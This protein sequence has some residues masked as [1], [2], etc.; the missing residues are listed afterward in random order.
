MEID[1]DAMDCVRCWLELG[2][3]F[4]LGMR[5]GAVARPALDSSFF[6]NLS[7]SLS[8]SLLLSLWLESYIVTD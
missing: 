6:L 3:P 2:F 1:R 7:R 4:R 8:P 5:D